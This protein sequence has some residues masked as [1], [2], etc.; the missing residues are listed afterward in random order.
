MG[1]RPQTVVRH[2]KLA[3]ERYGVDKRT[4][5]I[6]RALLDGTLSLAD[7]DPV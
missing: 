6:T 3:R 4:L 1:C 7:L 2:I 5:L